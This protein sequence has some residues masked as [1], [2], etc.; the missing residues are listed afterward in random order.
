MTAD[1]RTN[2]TVPGTAEAE[3][4]IAAAERAG[5]APFVDLSTIDLSAVRAG[6]EEVAR[7]NPHRHEMALLDTVI[8]IS[9][10]H[11]LTVGRHE[12]TPDAFWVRGHFPQRAT[13]PG[14]LMV[15]AAAQLSLYLWN[16]QQPTPRIAVFLRITEATFRRAV[17]PGDMLYLLCR[18]CKMGRRRFVS[19]LQGVVNGELAFEATIGGM[20]MEEYRGE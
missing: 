18:E 14:V 4:S 19:D 16:I 1:H 13:M 9:D 11:K 6:P 10:D 15:E 17:V 20:A 2:T 8:W 12:A 3:S 5:R 7:V